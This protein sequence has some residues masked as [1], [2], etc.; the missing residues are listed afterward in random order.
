FEEGNATARECL[1]DYYMDR[2]RDAEAERDEEQRAFVLDFLAKYHDG[3]YTRELIGDG[4]LELGS[5]PAGAEV[6]LCEL[7][8]AGFAVVRGTERRLGTTP[9]GPTALG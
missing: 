6:W 1:A 9:L 5:E 7:R 3:K 4:T 8:E 2:L